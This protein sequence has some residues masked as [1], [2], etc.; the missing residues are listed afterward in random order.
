MERSF[1][2]IMNVNGFFSAHSPNEKNAWEVLRQAKQ[3]T[4]I[5]TLKGNGKGKIGSNHEPRS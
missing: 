3:A 2:V 5:V 4:M 1:E